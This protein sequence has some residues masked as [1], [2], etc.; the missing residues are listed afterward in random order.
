MLDS[1]KLTPKTTQGH[2]GIYS[3]G[4]PSRT[5]VDLF[6][7]DGGRIIPLTGRLIS[8]EDLIDAYNWGRLEAKEAEKA[9]DAS[10]SSDSKYSEAPAF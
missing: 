6:V 7:T 3:A 2:C 4:D 5:S 1:L 10:W 8:R 9:Y